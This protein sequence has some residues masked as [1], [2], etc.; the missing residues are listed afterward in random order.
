MRN[1]IKNELFVPVLL[2]TVVPKVFTSFGWYGCN[3]LKNLRFKIM[4]LHPYQRKL[5]IYYERLVTLN[6][7]LAKL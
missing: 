4:Y 7:V 6:K 1:Y 2:G 5:V 3:Y